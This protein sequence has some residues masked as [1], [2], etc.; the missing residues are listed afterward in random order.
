MKQL[1][2]SA[3]FFGVGSVALQVKPATVALEKIVYV[4]RKRLWNMLLLGIIA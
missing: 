2:K 1:A 4:S 3:I